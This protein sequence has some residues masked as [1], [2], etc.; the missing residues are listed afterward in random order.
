ML[1]IMGLCILRDIDYAS[2]LSQDEY[3][4]SR[5]AAI[6]GVTIENTS[7]TGNLVL[8]KHFGPKV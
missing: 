1:H 7:E 3:F 2:I 5:A 6:A 8:I 4:V